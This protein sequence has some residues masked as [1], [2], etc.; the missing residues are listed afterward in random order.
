MYWY[1]ASETPDYFNACVDTIASVPSN[2]LG[3]QPAFDG[4][5]YSGIS[6]FLFDD[7]R[8]MIGTELVDSLVVGTTYF[9]SLYVN[10]ALG[11]IQPHDLG[12]N[13]TGVL[14]TMQEYQWMQGMPEF[15]LRDF[16]HVYTSDVITD[17]LNWTLVSGSFVADSAYPYLVIGNHFHNALTSTQ[18]IGVPQAGWAYTYIDQICVSPDSLGCPLVDNIDEDRL[19]DIR[20][21]PNPCVDEL[22]VRVPVG[23]HWLARIVD[24]GGREVTRT[25]F[26]SEF[27]SV[28]TA[29][30]SSGLWFLQLIGEK[31][32]RSFRFVVK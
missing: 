13:N 7:H 21:W 2:I 25:N 31:E 23:Q 27:N 20:L 6:P 19:N 14:F 30:L 9:V 3:Y 8:E 26:N 10:A 22:Y 5:A 29:G 17:T 11:G 18:L 24:N 28:N 4:Q 12:C 1:S 15:Q 32:N 16:A